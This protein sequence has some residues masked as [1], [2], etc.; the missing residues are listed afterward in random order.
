M[1]KGTVSVETKLKTNTLTHKGHQDT[2]VGQ[3]SSGLIEV[4][5]GETETERE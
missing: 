4:K 5:T 2:A 3:V 1:F